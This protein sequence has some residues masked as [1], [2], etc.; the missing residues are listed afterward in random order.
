M[1]PHNPQDAQAELRADLL[2]LAEGLAQALGTSEWTVDPR[3]VPDWHPCVELIRTEDGS[4]I[5]I[6]QER[7]H[8][9]RWWMHSSLPDNATYYD[10]HGLETGSITVTRAKTPTQ[11]ARD[12]QRRLL[13]ALDAAVAE[14]S[15][16]QHR[17]LTDVHEV[18]TIA[19]QL[20]AVPLTTG[21]PPGADSRRNG[22]DTTRT[23]RWNQGPDASWS[24]PHAEIKISRSRFGGVHIECSHL[25]AAMAE[26]VLRA[27]N[28]SLPTTQAAS[29]A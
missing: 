12:V 1:T 28:A 8:H 29:A 20:K 17:H 23:L 10:R 11:V 9:D 4:R 2:T 24:A 7:L 5:L 25:N 15:R 14:M 13:P 26:A 27:L 21:R 22:E 16:R 3:R 18:T 6:Q 19:R